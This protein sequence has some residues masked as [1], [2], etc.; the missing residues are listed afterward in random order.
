VLT[1]DERVRDLQDEDKRYQIAK[2][3]ADNLTI[4]YN[5]SEVI[6]AR[7]NQTTSAKERV[8]EATE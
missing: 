8:Q 2:D 6:M 1:R 5:T 4:S 3:L 7:L